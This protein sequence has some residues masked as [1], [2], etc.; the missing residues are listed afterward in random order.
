MPPRG[1][2]AA[3]PDL[4]RSLLFVPGDSERKLAR[5]VTAGAD[6]LIL[7]LEDAVVP[8]RKQQARDIVLNALQKR[9]KKGPTYFVRINALSSDLVLHD[10]AIV[11]QGAPDGIVL[12]KCAGLDQIQVLDQ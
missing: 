2:D 11:M 8:D 10:L 5:A 9:P 4:M 7:D 6:A 12:P 1:V 3:A